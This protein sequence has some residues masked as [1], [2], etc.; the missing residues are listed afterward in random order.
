[1]RNWHWIQLGVLALLS[2]SAAAQAQPAS[3]QPRSALEARDNSRFVR[4]FSEAEWYFSWGY[5]KQ[6][7]APTDIHVSQPSQGND[8]TIHDVRGEDFP[9]LTSQAITGALAGGLF[10]P[11]YNIRI[12][13]FINDSRTVAVE[14]NFDHTKYT[15]TEGQTARVSGLIAGMPTD[16]NHVLD[17]EFFAYA[18]HNGANHVMVNAVYRFP[19]IGQTNE[20]LSVAA[21]GKAGLGLM[22][23]HT[24]DT[25]LGKDSDV[26]KKELG[27][28]LGIHSGWWQLN[29]WTTG[30]EA[31]LRVV[32]FKPV[33]LELTDKLAYAGL[34]N[35]PAY[36][37]TMQHSLLMNEVVLSLGFT[38]DGV[39]RR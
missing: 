22:V 7:W 11:Q 39:S 24:S 20:T 33:Y 18:L 37:G 23:P 38:Y 10:G 8:F 4:F 34:W 6:Y 19:L 5:S 15:T 3:G 16:A 29:G 17:K 30:V 9:N 32:L 28:L 27:N 1:M 25:I 2:A 31:G 12:G 36:Q 13:R 21:V 14:F 35:V 26:G